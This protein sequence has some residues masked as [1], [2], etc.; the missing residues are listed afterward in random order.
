MA[1]C[2]F[3]NEFSRLIKVKSIVSGE[4]SND[5]GKWTKLVTI[6]IESKDSI[7]ENTI[8]LMEAEIIYMCL[9]MVIDDAKK[10]ASMHPQTLP[11]ENNNNNNNNKVS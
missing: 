10:T 7:S 8:T 6:T 4:K 2:E 3:L 9:G 1:K 5:E 11:P